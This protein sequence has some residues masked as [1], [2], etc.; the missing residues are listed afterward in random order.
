MVA[1]SP[2]PIVPA[3]IK[4][5]AKPGQSQALLRYVKS[6]E[7]LRQCSLVCFSDASHLV[8][9]TH[10]LVGR[11]Y[12]KIILKRLNE[13]KTYSCL[14]YTTCEFPACTGIVI[15]RFLHRCCVS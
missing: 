13:I 2:A 7:F 3:K 5:L 12:L 15:P 4:G 1:V 9:V 10:L 11:S 14:L 8:L 6:V